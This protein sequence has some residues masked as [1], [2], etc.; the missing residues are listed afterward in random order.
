[1][2]QCGY[3]FRIESELAYWHIGT[4]LTLFYRTGN[5]VIRRV[6]QP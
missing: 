3:S 2:C 5:S 1:M 4:L 6:V